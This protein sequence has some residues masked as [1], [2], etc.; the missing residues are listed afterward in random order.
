MFAPFF[1]FSGSLYI[2]KIFGKTT[3]L[4]EI[5]TKS[6][7]F[8]KRENIEAFENQSNFADDLIAMVNYKI[9][10]RANVITAGDLIERLNE[11]GLKSVRNLGVKSFSEIQTKI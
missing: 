8:A 1:D 10:S 2:S 4:K 7:Q 5:F 3:L 11:G 9:A 6:S